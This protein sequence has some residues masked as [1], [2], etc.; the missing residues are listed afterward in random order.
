MVF[1]SLSTLVC[2]STSIG[3][4]Q[5]KKGPGE[6]SGSS[7]GSGTG[8]GGDSG[9]DSGGGSSPCVNT[10]LLPLSDVIPTQYKNSTDLE[11]YGGSFFQGEATLQYSIEVS[12]NSRTQCS[13]TSSILKLLGVAWLGPQ[14]SWPPGPSNLFVLGF[15]AWKSDELVD[16]ITFSYDT[17]AMYPDV[18]HLESTSSYAYTYEG[19]TI[20]GATDT[21][22]MTVMSSS[23]DASTLLFSG[24]YVGGI[25][26]TLQATY[27]QD[28]DGDTITLPAGSCPRYAEINGPISIGTVINGSITN[29]TVTLSISGTAIP[30]DVKAV[31][32]TEVFSDLAVYFNATFKGFLDM[33]NSTQSIT[34][35]QSPELEISWE[36]TS[37]APTL[38]LSR[39]LWWTWFQTMGLS[40]L[41][42]WLPAF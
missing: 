22:N 13:N 18:V 17:C 8:G 16:N 12:E 25:A 31:T 3:L 4:I 29:Q 2:L 36:S 27:L 39:C 40:I 34:I 11:D 6:S 37:L 21:V 19:E 26:E 33:A 1:I 15:K 7:G 32:T 9:D 35:Q 23:R 41:G 10:H 42:I 28:S 14:A 5:A 38:T 30:E 20:Y 24:V